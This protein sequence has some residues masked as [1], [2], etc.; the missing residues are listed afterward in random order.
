MNLRTEHELVNEVQRLGGFKAKKE[1]VTVALQ[2][3]IDR[4]KQLEILK[5]FGTIDFDPTYEHKKWRNL[6]RIPRS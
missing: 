5:L 1:A 6:G 3:Y 4:R 2:E